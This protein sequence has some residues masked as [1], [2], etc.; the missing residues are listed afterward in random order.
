MQPGPHLC[1]SA[2]SVRQDEAKRLVRLVDNPAGAAEADAMRQEHRRARLAASPA[3]TRR[4][5]VEASQRKECGGIQYE[6]CGGIQ[7]KECAESC[8]KQRMHPS[9]C[10]CMLK[11]ELKLALP[12]R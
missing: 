3:T 2:P 11:N 5:P 4:D 12:Q 9:V 6:K 7:Y 1:G 10:A 8:S